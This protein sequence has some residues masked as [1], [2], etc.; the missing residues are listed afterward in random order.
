MVRV[1]V[2]ASAVEYL[3]SHS[4]RWVTGWEIGD[5]VYKGICSPRAPHML[6]RRARRAGIPIESSELGYRIGRNKEL[7]CPSCGALRVLYPDELI[8]YSCVGTEFADLEVGRSQGEGE[9]S[10]KAWTPSE[11][12][13]VRANKDRMSHREMGELLQ[14]SEAAVRGYTRTRGLDKRY[15]LTKPRGKR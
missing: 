10:G 9:R 13:F 8:C 5:F 7:T 6:I 1:P 4:G 2:W 12:A 11:E 3:V 15:V 14:R